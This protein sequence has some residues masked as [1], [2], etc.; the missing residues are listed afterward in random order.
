MAAPL[1]A[2]ALISA[3]ASLVSG[4]LGSNSAK[5]QNQAANAQSQKEM[6]FQERMSSTAHQRE[7]A[8]LRA[9][10]LNPILSANTGASSPM[11]SMAPVVNETEPLRDTLKHSAADIANI[12]LTKETVM[13]QRSQQR[14]N[15]ANAAK[16]LAEASGFLGNPVLGRIPLSSAKRF[17]QQHFGHWK[18]PADIFV[19]P[20]NAITKR[21]RFATQKG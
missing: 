16:S 2:A 14:L 12:A 1:V 8:D 20:Y 6:D 17:T 19:Q 15:D 18:S 21:G 4:I 7:V 10:G 5:S 3:G 13:T 11:G 9:A